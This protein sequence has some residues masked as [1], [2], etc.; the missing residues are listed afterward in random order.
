MGA[1]TKATRWLLISLI[2]T[3]V[4]CGSDD[5]AAHTNVAPAPRASFGWK[6]ALAQSG[7][8]LLAQHSARAMQPKTHREFG[9]PFFRDYVNAASAIHTWHDQDSAF[10][11]YFGH[12]LM[13]TITGYV[14]VFNDPRGQ[15]L[16]FAAGSREYWKSRF[17]AMAWSAAYSTQFE[18]GPISEAS[19]GNVGRRPGTMGVTDLVITPIGGFGLMVLE[20][21]LDKRFI[22]RW[23]GRRSKNAA[24]F[25]RVA[26]NPGRSMANLLRFKSPSHRDT[27][28][29]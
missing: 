11:N 10:T 26:L 23:E 25:L 19:I 1:C 16:E 22:S 5:R 27:R 7:L 3:G 9:G 2:S 17:R 21:Y 20:D 15:R 12:P 4:V 8:F 28:G 29:L 14:Q 18:L 24:R 13:G 6:P